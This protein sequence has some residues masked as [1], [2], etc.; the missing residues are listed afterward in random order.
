MTRTGDEA[1]AK[2]RANPAFDAV[3][4]DIVMPGS[5]N[6]TEL[7]R[8]LRDEFPHIPVVLATGY[9][10]E[11]TSP[12]ATTILAKPYSVQALITALREATRRTTHQLAPA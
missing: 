2:L 1:L 9:A 8:I 3:F 6:G 11:V 12:N 7:A 10:A 4:S 5:L